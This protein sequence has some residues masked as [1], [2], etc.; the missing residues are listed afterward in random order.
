MERS[1]IL[2]LKPAAEENPGLYRSG[3]Q[4]RNQ[5]KKEE[6]NV[7]VQL[8]SEYHFISFLFLFFLLRHPYQGLGKKNQFKNVNNMYCNY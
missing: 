3:G 8:R 6:K 2:S 4:K 5:K 1:Q 7:T